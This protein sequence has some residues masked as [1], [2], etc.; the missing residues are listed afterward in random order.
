MLE[1]TRRSML[2]TLRS[3]A[4]PRRY[5]STIPGRNRLEVPYSRRAGF[6]SFR[7]VIFVGDFP[8]DSICM[9]QSVQSR[10]NES[11]KLCGQ[12]QCRPHVIGQIPLH[13]IADAP[14]GLVGPV[15]RVQTSQSEQQYSSATADADERQFPSHANLRAVRDSVGKRLGSR[16]AGCEAGPSLRHATAPSFY[17]PR[18]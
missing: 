3:E 18:S 4:P 13:Q 15:D 6:S 17:K 10:N 1:Q 14:V 9:D 2:S 11:H 12:E 8:R 5:S 7:P 16:I